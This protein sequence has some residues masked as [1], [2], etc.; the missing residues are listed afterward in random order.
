MLPFATDTVV[1][2]HAGVVADPYNK[3]VRDW[4][5][6][7]RTTL[8]AAVQPLS[9][10]EV[11]DGRDQTI[12]TYRC[13]LDPGTAVIAQDRLEW[14]GLVLE[15]DGDPAPWKGPMPVLDHVEVIGKVVAG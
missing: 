8:R 2:V 9:S 5:N 10:T 11:T 6:A 4:A 3:L 14:N 1:L 7:T 15:V 13:F 12:S